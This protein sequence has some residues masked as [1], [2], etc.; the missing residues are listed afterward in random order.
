ML[1]QRHKG[2]AATVG[3]IAP[4]PPF[5]L[6]LPRAGHAGP[7]LRLSDSLS[8]APFH[9]RRRQA[10]PQGVQGAL[11][12][13]PQPELVARRDRGEDA[14]PGRR[15]GLSEAGW[16]RQPQDG[17]AFCG[18]MQE[19]GGDA[20]GR[21]PTT[22]TDWL[23]SGRA[24]APAPPWP[25]RPPSTA[26]AEGSKCRLFGRPFRDGR[27]SG[28]QDHPRT[29]NAPRGDRGEGRGE[30]VAS[31]VFRSRTGVKEGLRDRG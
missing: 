31:D 8:L 27:T 20:G 11:T 29:S 4:G 9:C 3:R 10:N 26:V 16:P 13:R 15:L 28:E 24:S 5:A 18:P 12:T 25:W 7:P 1:E 2:L 6:A 19:G 23:R 22:A 30:G 21:A 17:A 14:F